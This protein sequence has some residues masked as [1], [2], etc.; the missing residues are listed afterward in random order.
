M[1]TPKAR[2]YPAGARQTEIEKDALVQLANPISAAYLKKHL[3]KTSPRLVL[4]P[5]LEK[6]LKNKIKSDP[7]VRNVYQALPFLKQVGSWPFAS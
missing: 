4:T 7:V 6:N 5:A 2:W 3:R 1:P